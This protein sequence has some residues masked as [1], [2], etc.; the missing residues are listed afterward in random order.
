MKIYKVKKNVVLFIGLL[1]LEIV[2]VTAITYSREYLWSSIQNRQLTLFLLVASFF[3]I[4]ALVICVVSGLQSYILNKVSLVWRHKITRR[5]FKKDLSHIEGYKQ[6]IQEDAWN[7]PNLRL[8]LGKRYFQ[9]TI[10]SIIYIIILMTKVSMIYLLFPLVYAVIGT[11]VGYYISRPLTMLNFTNQVCEAK[12]RETLGKAL[13]G[14]VYRNNYNVFRKTKHVDYF[15]GFYGQLGVIFPYLSLA[16]AYFN[17]GISFPVL[18]LLAP[19]IG[20]LIDHFGV[21]ISNYGINNKYHACKKRLK[22]L[23]VI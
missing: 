18:M 8:T 19:I 2:S 20:S 21:I 13:F 12:F 7:Y 10:M 17:G 22:G 9:A 16:P 11:I 23:D 3:T 5:A 15:Q 6:R 1:T 14:T 4:I